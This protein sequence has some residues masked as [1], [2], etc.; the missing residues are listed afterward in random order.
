MTSR[1]MAQSHLHQARRIQVEAGRHHADGAWHLV[2]RR[3]QEAVELGL[4]AVLRTAG[5]EVPKV[6]DV[7]VFLR[8]HADHLPRAVR[9][10]L[11]RVTSISRRLREER[12]LSFYGDEAVEAPPEQLYSKLDGDQALADARLVLDLCELALSDPGTT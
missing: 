8:E 1:E 10:E 4:K 6:H 9:V 3:C 5:L 11:D 12:E 2:V 7:G